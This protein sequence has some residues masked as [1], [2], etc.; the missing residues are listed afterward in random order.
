MDVLNI[1]TVKREIVEARIA[2]IWKK[3][4]FCHV[5]I[6]DKAVIDVD[7]VKELDNVVKRLMGERKSLIIADLS[8]IRY[9]TFEARKYRAIAEFSG[10]IGALALIIEN[11]IAQVIGNFF[12]GINKPQFPV[13]LFHSKSNGV[14]WLR[15]HAQL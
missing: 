5:K 8:Q 2:Q 1:D 9:V 7:D 3:D 11:P 4:G 6:K 13:K 12:I 15:V 10:H 14:G